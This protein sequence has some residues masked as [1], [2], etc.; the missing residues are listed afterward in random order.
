MSVSVYTIREYEGQYLCLTVD[1]NNDDDDD[2]SR[3][4]YQVILFA[5]DIIQRKRSRRGR[6]GEEQGKE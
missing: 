5:I 3:D 6:L 1:D 4:D 2:F